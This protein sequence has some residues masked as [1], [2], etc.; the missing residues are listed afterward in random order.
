MTMPKVP[1]IAQPGALLIMMDGQ[2]PHIEPK[3]IALANDLKKAVSD[4]FTETE[5][6]FVTDRTFTEFLLMFDLFDEF[7]T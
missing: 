7:I 5:S 6:K 4:H 1:T 2:Q 3:N